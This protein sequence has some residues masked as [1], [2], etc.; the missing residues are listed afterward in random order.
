MEEI[1]RDA[2]SFVT[3]CL[4]KNVVASRMSYS[5][6]KLCLNLVGLQVNEKHV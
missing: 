3:L 4:A 1:K 6:V 2:N 5:I